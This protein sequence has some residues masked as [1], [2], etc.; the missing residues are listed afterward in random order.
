MS[1]ERDEERMKR[2]EEDV[3]RLESEVKETKLC[4]S[5]NW[6]IAQK[7]IVSCFLH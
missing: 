6:K 2:Q 1:F 7:V 4:T 5:V 3:G